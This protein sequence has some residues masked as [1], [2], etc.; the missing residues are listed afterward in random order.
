MKNNPFL[1][2]K[3]NLA[4]TPIYIMIKFNIARLFHLGIGAG[5]WRN[6]DDASP[7]PIVER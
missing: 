2:L 3:K 6:L 5:N 1:I 4:L 7:Y